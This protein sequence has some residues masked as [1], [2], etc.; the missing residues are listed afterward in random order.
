MYQSNVITVYLPLQKLKLPFKAFHSSRK[1]RNVF[2]FYL[3]SYNSVD[4][5]IR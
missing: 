3:N 4:N 2:I 5:C 1:Y